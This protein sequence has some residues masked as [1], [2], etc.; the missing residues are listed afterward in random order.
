VSKGLLRVTAETA[1]ITA[2]TKYQ[3]LLLRRLNEGLKHCQWFQSAAPQFMPPKPRATVPSF[4]RV[5]SRR[6]HT[7][8]LWYRESVHPRRSVNSIKALRTIAL[9]F[10]QSP[11]FLARHANRFATLLFDQTAVGK[12]SRGAEIARNHTRVAPE[13]LTSLARTPK[14]LGTRRAIHRIIAVAFYNRRCRRTAHD[15][16]AFLAL[17]KL[18]RFHNGHKNLQCRQ[19][20]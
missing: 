12:C 14:L 11:V 2:I 5:R 6:N 13:Q 10:V 7:P 20:G 3:R 18:G 8:V 4:R 15:R 16:A 19:Q 1:T 9:V 17:L